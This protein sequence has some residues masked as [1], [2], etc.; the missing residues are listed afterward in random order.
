VSDE[1]RAAGRSGPNRRE[2]LKAGMVAG[3]VVGT[4]GWRYAARSPLDEG[5][6]RQPG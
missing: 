2:L 4:G 5:D 1:Q 3:A 6:L